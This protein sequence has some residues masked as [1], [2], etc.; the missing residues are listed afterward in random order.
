MS[1]I[2]NMGLVNK[3]KDRTIKQIPVNLLVENPDNFYCVGDVEEL[4]YSII[5]AGGVRQ[6]LVVEPMD[7]GR[8]MIVSGHRRCKAVKQLLKE[9]TVGIPDTVP[10]EISTDHYGNQLLLIETNSTAR[11][12]TAWERVEQYIR[13]NSLFKYGIMTKKINGRKR[14]AIAEVLHESK[15]NIARYSA[16]SNNLRKYYTD[17]MKSGKLGIEYNHQSLAADPDFTGSEFIT[18]RTK[19]ERLGVDERL[20]RDF[21]SWIV[22]GLGM[23]GK[24]QRRAAMASIEASYIYLFLA[25]H[26]LFG[27][28]AQR[29]KAIQQKI[30]FYAGCIREGEPG[31]E[32][33][34]KCMAVECGQVYP[35]LIACEEK[36]GEVKIYG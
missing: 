14:D 26:E 30:K 20:E 34:M 35:G 3:D 4:K 16:I 28:G 2:E 29:L 22:S 8:Y 36:Y 5:A 12:L 15:T 7:D 25:I 33:F 31:I 6:N 13:L 1:L 27:F 9:Q 19:M 24:E 11:E 10:C 32:E 18:M 23:K 17:W 21:I